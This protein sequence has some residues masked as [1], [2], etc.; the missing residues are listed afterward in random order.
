[1]VTIRAAGSILNA[2]NDLFVNVLGGN[3][4]L[5]ADAGSIGSLA[6][7]LNVGTSPGGNI[8]AT[9][10]HGL[11]DL[12]GVAGL[13]FTIGS[14]LAGT[15]TKLVAAV[16]GT[17]DGPVTA[18]TDIAMSAGGRL[19]LTA[20]ANVI[21]G[22]GQVLVSADTM[23]ML[24]GS[25]ITASLGSVQVNTVNDALVTGI[26]SG[27]ADINAISIN[28]GGHVLAGTDPARPFDLSAMT[29]GA[30]IKLVAGL[31]IGDET[32]AD[33]FAVDQKGSPV[34]SANLITAVANPLILRTNAI[35][36]TATKGDADLVTVTTINSGSVVTGAGNINIVANQ[37][38][39]ASNLSATQGNVVVN[40]A[41][42]I[43][44]GNV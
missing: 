43:T 6:N 17:I 15:S 16:D 11:V 34:G 3:V 13:D 29:A 2:N 10:S 33:N 25:R 32:E 12:Y 14:D 42:S 38:F 30:G 31:G 8:N 18:G 20:S 37:D 4:V 44:V 24:N 26:I 21:S 36:V 1:M 41:G 19:V 27:S 22:A 39:T 23:K 28:S 40:S 7:S 35:D 9:A 5:M